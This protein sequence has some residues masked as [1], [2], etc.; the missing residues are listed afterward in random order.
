MEVKKLIPNAM[1]GGSHRAVCT[2]EMGKVTVSPAM[3]SNISES[4]T[5]RAG[6]DPPDNTVHGEL[7][8]RA[9]RTSRGC[10]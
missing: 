4:A 3:A 6:A 5:P 7:C 9:L 2:P 1:S 8:R 10:G